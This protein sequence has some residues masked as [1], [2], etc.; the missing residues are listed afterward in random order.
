MRAANAAR[1]RAELATCLLHDH[2]PDVHAANLSPCTTFNLM[3]YGVK[4]QCA[5][6]MR[7]RELTWPEF[8]RTRISHEP[9]HV[10]FR[11]A[12]ICRECG[13]GPLELAFSRA[14]T[15]GG[16]AAVGRISRRPPPERK[17]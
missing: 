12:I 5:G 3:H 1:D 6:C 8:A 4:V 16:A 9:W 2:G 17:V 11:S 15:G 14:P 10:I 7:R 13:H